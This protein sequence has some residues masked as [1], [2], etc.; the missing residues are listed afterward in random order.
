MN[1]SYLVIIIS[2]SVVTSIHEPAINEED[3]SNVTNTDIP[4]E[5]LILKANSII[6]KNICT[7]VENI[8]YCLFKNE[9]FHV[10]IFDDTTF[11]TL[12]RM[13]GKC[14]EMIIDIC[15]DFLE[16]NYD[17]M[18]NI[19]KVIEFFCYNDNIT[20]HLNNQNNNNDNNNIENDNN[21][22]NN[23]EIKNIEND[24]DEINNIENDNNENNKDNN[25]NIENDNKE[26]NN[27]EINN[28][29][30]YNN[31]NNNDENNNNEINNNKND[32]LDKEDCIKISKSCF[33]NFAYDLLNH[34]SNKF[35]IEI[36][37]SLN[38][39]EKKFIKD[40]IAKYNDVYN[41]SL[42]EHKE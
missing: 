39:V 28:I 9:E 21:E 8:Q 29:E 18:I 2:T 13:V 42:E 26:N 7:V 36:W 41:K 20:L 35:T 25:T 12:L 11:G 34:E 3:V 10:G 27:D 38:D 24:N 5:N 4:N 17:V 32:T 30:N 6:S 15:Y 23:D 37:K 33:K 22:N 19:E 14:N 31:E 16:T 40:I 1:F